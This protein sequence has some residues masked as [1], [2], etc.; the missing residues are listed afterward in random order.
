MKKDAFKLGIKEM[1]D[2]FKH[3]GSID[4]VGAYEKGSDTESER[5]GG[6]LASSS[7]RSGDGRAPV[8]REESAVFGR[9]W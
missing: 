6:L 2:L 8:R 9:R 5:S 3:E 4:Y 1:L 7:Q